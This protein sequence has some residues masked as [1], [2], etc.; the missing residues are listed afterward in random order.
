MLDG[1]RA[2][3]PYVSWHPGRSYRYT[4]AVFQLN[5]VALVLLACALPVVPWRHVF[6]LA[7]WGALLA[8]HPVSRAFARAM[9]G[10]S[11]TKTLR[12]VTKAR[13]DWLMRDDALD[14]AALDPKREI[15]LVARY[16]NER[17]I[18]NV[19]ASSAAAAA[20]AAAAGSDE[21]RGDKHDGALTFAPEPPTGGELPEGFEWLRERQDA[22]MPPED[23]PWVI[24]TIGDWAGH[25]DE[26]GWVY[27][28][29]DGSTASSA[30]KLRPSAT[31][32]AAQRMTAYARRR[33]WLRRAI[34]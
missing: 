24:D 27:L 1:A 28:F 34:S 32:A 31:G 29:A 33:R 6:L 26:E 17:V 7:G 21:K 11:S 20:T 18:G 9:R 23:E 30:S 22:A 10:A 3:S 8:L 14:D 4:L 13:V 15:V 25:V 19:D 16:E 12:R 5:L 2:L